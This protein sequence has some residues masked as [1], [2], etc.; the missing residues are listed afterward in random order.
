ML[1]Y[2]PLKQPT[3]QQVLIEKISNG[4][5][6][7]LVI[8]AHTNIAIFLMTNPH[9]KK[10]I[11]HIYIMGGGVRSKNP[12][13]GNHGNLYTCFK[14]NPYAEFNLFDDPFAA[15]QVTNYRSFLKLVLIRWVAGQE[16]YGYYILC[17]N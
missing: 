9:L 14:S 17:V 5:I 6:S 1:R 3:A 8:G 2:S 16:M 15:Y 12:T 11:E 10:N 7:L 13:G 4:P